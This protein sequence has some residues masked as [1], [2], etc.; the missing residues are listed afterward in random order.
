MVCHLEPTTSTGNQPLYLCP[1]ISHHP[2][3]YPD[4]FVGLWRIHIFP[5]GFCGGSTSPCCF[6]G[7]RGRACPWESV[8]AGDVCPPGS[9]CLGRRA[10]HHPLCLTLSQG[11][12]QARLLNPGHVISHRIPLFWGYWRKMKGCR[13]TTGIHIHMSVL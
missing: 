11:K 10:S 8:W 3:S 2:V 5:G 1:C 7:T 12:V 4:V 13:L 6:V 9:P